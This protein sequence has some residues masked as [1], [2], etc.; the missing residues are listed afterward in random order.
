MPGLKRSLR[1]DAELDRDTEYQ[2]D[3]ERVN[4]HVRVLARISVP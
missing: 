4:G 2:E 1:P 3:A